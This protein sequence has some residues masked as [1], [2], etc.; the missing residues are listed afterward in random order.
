MD[1]VT[2]S[3]VKP[4]GLESS[5]FILRHC[6]YCMRM[7]MILLEIQEVSVIRR[8]LAFLNLLFWLG[9]IWVCCSQGRSEAHCLRNV[10]EDCSA[11]ARGR[12]AGPGQALSFPFSFFWKNEQK[13]I[14]VAYFLEMKMKWAG[15]RRKQVCFFSRV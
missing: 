4:S 2:D 9:V 6:G 14:S 5:T 13:I 7:P 11:N 3:R 8:H 12:K 15:T 10:E 1:V